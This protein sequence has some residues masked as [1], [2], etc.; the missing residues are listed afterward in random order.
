MNVAYYVSSDKI[1]LYKYGL[2]FSGPV[3]YV[4]LRNCSYINSYA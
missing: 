2:D 3:T 1:D 4:R